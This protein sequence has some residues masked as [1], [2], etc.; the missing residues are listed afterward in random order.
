MVKVFD[1]AFSPSKKV[2]TIERI[3]SHKRKIEH[4]KNLKLESLLGHLN[5][6]LAQSE[7]NA[8]SQFRNPQYP[9]IFIV[10]CARS[11][12]TLLFQ[13]ISDLGLFAYPSNLMSRFYR[14]PYIG[15]LIQQLLTDPEY[16]FREELIEFQLSE[17]NYA[18]DLGKTRGAL[19][20]NSFLYFWREYFKF[21]EIQKL[22]P[23]AIDSV[24]S[25]ALSSELAAIESVFGKPL[26][27]KAMIMNWHIDY[28]NQIF[29]NSLF[30]HIH[31]DPLMHAQSL[32]S[33]RQA[34][35]GSIEP[36]YSYKPP[37]YTHL[38]G[39]SPY[40]QV[41]GQVFFTNEAISDQL[42]MLNP[43]HYL[44]IEYESLCSNPQSVFIDILKKLDKLGFS[45][46]L[47][48]T[49]PNSFAKSDNLTLSNQEKVNILE[50]YDQFT[51]PG[52]KLGTYG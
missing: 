44:T 1:Q 48:Y 20:P 14:A 39:L 13:W 43:D 31:R 40:W 27:M 24:N 38:K 5:E 49:G 36:W 47:H 3:M 2:T 4:R 7:V 8:V 11:G 15:A 12:S 18:S 25:A 32:L 46:D 29:P 35:Y 6:L 33:A 9:V 30:L 37:E 51:H 26:A 23:E 34:F 16:A 19:S 22:G 52:K 17:I 41:A 10:G 21:G 45:S 42:L 28:L 50:A